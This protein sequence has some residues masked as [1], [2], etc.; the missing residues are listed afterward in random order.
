MPLNNFSK[1]GE[2]E[3]PLRLKTAES[4]YGLQNSSED[5]SGKSHGQNQFNWNKML[6]ED[7]EDMLKTKVD[8]HYEEIMQRKKQEAARR[9]TLIDAKHDP[10][11]HASTGVHSL[12]TQ[13]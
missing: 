7:L 6:N 8:K 3:V 10:A 2:G 5:V 12:N 13:L 11:I 1:K 4:S 9:K